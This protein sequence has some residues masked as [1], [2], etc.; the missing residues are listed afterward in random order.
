MLFNRKLL[1]N[2]GI[3]L[4]ITSLISDI[5][6]SPG[7]RARKKKNSQEKKNSQVPP[8]QAN[9]AAV[10]ARI[11]SA[12]SVPAPVPPRIASA[13]LRSPAHPSDA[14]PP[15]RTIFWD[16]LIENINNKEILKQ[17]ALPEAWENHPVKH[18]WEGKQD[19]LDYSHLRS[20]ILSAISILIELTK[21]AQQEIP[22]YSFGITHIDISNAILLNS[23]IEFMNSLP[24]LRT[25]S[26]SGYKFARDTPQF[27]SL[28]IVVA[29]LIISSPELEVL[30][31]LKPVK[32]Y[33]KDA[34][35]YSNRRDTSGEACI[36]GFG[37]KQL[38]ILLLSLPTTMKEILL[39]DSELEDEGAAT[40]Q[41]FR[42]L[43]VLDIKNC[44]NLNSPVI[45][46]LLQHLPSSIEKLGILNKD[47]D[48]TVN[49]L[50]LSNWKRLPFDSWPHL[51]SRMP[52]DLK[53]LNLSQTV[54]K[55]EAL[56]NISLFKELEE[57]N[58]IDCRFLSSD[59]IKAYMSSITPTMK[60]LF[61][62]RTKVTFD[63]IQKL[64]ELDFQLEELHI[65]ETG[66]SEHNIQEIREKMENTV[67]VHSYSWDYSYNRN[68]GHPQAGGCT[69]H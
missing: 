47:I 63:A 14:P 56:T 66:I 31:L 12:P 54:I 60:K 39:P 43:K 44:Q 59:G 16:E 61:L 34:F 58:L 36:A 69:I 55:D 48:F 29:N 52:R 18:H 64:L 22:D 32:R 1:H 33:S 26:I 2:L 15:Y 5:N 53:K 49:D 24:H 30:R 17:L 38:N 21:I 50:N 68:E 40:L 28:N 41:R 62:N 9:P 42:Q 46:I 65:W 37:S 27:F 23:T 67:I 13:P 10:P 4:L 51:L 45:H 7:G 3:L 19:R 20:D 6:G 11:P 35:L 25:L 8:A 57:L